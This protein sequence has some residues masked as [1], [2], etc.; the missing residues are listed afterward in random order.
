MKQLYKNYFLVGPYFEDKAKLNFNEEEPPQ[1]IKDIFDALEKYEGIKCHYGTWLI[2]SEPKAILIE[3]K[4]I[5]Y[6]INELKKYFWENFQIDSLNSKWE[7]EEPMLWSFATGLLIDKFQEK[8]SK[9]NVLGHFHEWLSGFGLLYLK[10]ENQNVK[11]VFTTHATMLGRTLAS[12]GYN[13]YSD[14]NKINPFDK[15]KEFGI[16]DKYTVE[17]ASAKNAN[18]FTTVSEIT[19]VEATHILGRKPDILTLNGLDLDKFPSIEQTSITHVE[20]KKKLR[21]YITYHF[22]PHYQFDLDHNLMFC[23]M[24]RPEFK[25]KGID[26]FIKALGKLNNFMKQN[27]IRKRTITV[28]FWLIYNNN[29]SKKELLQNKERFYHIKSFINNNSEKMLN[30]IINNFITNKSINME[31]V[32]SRKFLIDIKKDVLLFKRKGNPPLCP[33]YLDNENNN[34]IIKSLYEEGLDNFEDDPV[35]IVFYPGFLDGNDSLLNLDIYTAV[36]GTHFAFFPSYYEPWGY[37]PLEAAA[38]EVPA[39]TT[40]LAGYGRFINSKTK[41]S[42]GI[43]ILERDKKSDEETI[44]ELFEIM[45]SFAELR[46]TER[47]Q[48]RVDAKNL[49]FLADWKFLIKNYVDSHNLALKQ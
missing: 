45:K 33:F 11:T 31:H 29:G 41:N 25:D 17:R 38:L 7:F 4:N 13:L 37:T 16:I 40:N 43:K 1:L 14:L 26:I 49:S 8:T 9:E 3:Y 10:K 19:G 28:F 30:K 36:C 2:D 32:F 23:T 22:F 48:L 12:N 20:S 39:L 21:E 5:S 42:K 34:E 15:A 6:K 44:K 35:K 47:V 46:H 18:V 27:P 24:G